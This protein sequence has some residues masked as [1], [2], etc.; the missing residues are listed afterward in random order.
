MGVARFFRGGRLDLDGNHHF[1]VLSA[2]PTTWAGWGWGLAMAGH[3]LDCC[4]PDTEANAWPWQYTVWTAAVWD[5]GWCLATAG[6][7]LDWCMRLR[8]M[9]GHGRTQ[10]GLLSAWHWGWCLAMAG[11]S[12]DCCLPDTEDDAWPW[13][14][15]VWTAAVWDWGWCLAMAGHSLDWC[16]PDTE[17][18]AWPWQDKVWTAVCLTLRM[19]LG[20]GSTQSGLLSAWDWGWCLA[21]A[22]HSLDCCLPDTEDDAWPWQY[23]VWTVVCLTLRMMLGHGRTQSGLLTAWHWGWCLAM[24]VHSLD[25][26]LPDTEGDAWPW[27]YTVWTPVCLR[28]TVILGNSSTGWTT[29]WDCSLNSWS[30]PCQSTRRSWP[31]PSLQILT[32]L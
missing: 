31:R 16:L 27:Q 32:S 3:S 24:A 10:S 13:Q 18:D 22:G 23:T 25:C 29:A 14:Y 2:P 6:H 19:M 15:T 11:H 12:L 21:M 9:L 4:L 30:T 26:C 17:D 20:H 28:L 1:A 7:S 5:W 8:V